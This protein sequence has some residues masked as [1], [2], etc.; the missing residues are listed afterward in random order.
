MNALIRNI[1]LRIFILCDVSTIWLLVLC[2]FQNLT[3]FFLIISISFSILI[4]ELYMVKPIDNYLHVQ[5]SITRMT[6]IITNRTSTPLFLNLICKQTSSVTNTS[7]ILI[8]EYTTK[9]MISPISVL[10]VITELK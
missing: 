4:T 7:L 3:F 8:L 6:T 1:F 9:Q 2:I 10:K 5:Q